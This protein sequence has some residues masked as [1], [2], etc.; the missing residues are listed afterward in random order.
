MEP[1][2]PLE[3]PALESPETEPGNTDLVSYPSGLP[4]LPEL[5]LPGQAALGQEIGCSAAPT[6]G[7]SF[8][9]LPLESVADGVSN[10]PG[11]SLE[12]SGTELHQ[13]AEE[14]GAAETSLDELTLEYTAPEPILAGDLFTVGGVPFNVSAEGD[15]SR[16]QA[17][18]RHEVGSIP[19]FL[20]EDF[21]IPDQ[22]TVS[23]SL[24]DDLTI[25]DETPEET[26]KPKPYQLDENHLSATQRKLNKFHPEPVKVKIDRGEAPYGPEKPVRSRGPARSRK[27]PGRRKRTHC[28]RCGGRV[29]FYRCEKCGTEYCACQEPKENGKCT[30][31]SCFLAELERED[32]NRA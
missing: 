3:L 8:D 5:N 25:V 24:P 28:S 18:G 13:G 2:N 21:S 22:I 23:H 31:E 9:Q 6:I 4:A 10:R 19:S 1:I 15:V 27:S 12:P 17:S 26:V 29:R 20:L 11:L 16:I 32:S 7:S 14:L 30:N